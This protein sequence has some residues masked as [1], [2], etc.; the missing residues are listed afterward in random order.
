MYAHLLD[1]YFT[2]YWSV[3]NSKG[4]L[5][6]PAAGGNAAASDAV[7][8]I[9][10]KL[11]T[12]MCIPNIFLYNRDIEGGIVDSFESE[13]TW[14]NVKAKTQ[15]DKTASEQ[16]GDGVNNQYQFLVRS[17]EN[18]F[19]K[20][21]LSYYYTLAGYTLT[22]RAS[23]LD[24][25]LT[26]VKGSSYAVITAYYKSAD[27]LAALAS[28]KSRGIEAFI[29]G[30]TVYYGDQD[31]LAV[32]DGKA[33]AESRGGAENPGGE[34]AETPVIPAPGGNS[35]EQGSGSENQ[36]PGTGEDC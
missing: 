11:Y 23:G 27:A 34:E 13:L 22:S 17:T 5:A 7:F 4:T 33:P 2:D 16:K 31:A 29:D 32:K 36:N 28:L 9:N 24:V 1:N 20:L 35:G 6:R 3:W 8:T 25:T 10:G 12:R 19:A 18:L 14:A 30:N 15:E 21:N 26:A